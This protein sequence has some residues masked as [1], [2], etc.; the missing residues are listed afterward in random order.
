MGGAAATVRPGPELQLSESA[1]QLVVPADMV[2]GAY[3]VTVGG[4]APFVCG[5]PDIWW[6]QGA[7]GNHSVAGSWMRVFGR[8]MALPDADDSTAERRRSIKA[9]HLA[10]R[11]KRAAH[12]G[13]WE[14]VAALAKELAATAGATGQCVVEEG[15]AYDGDDIL[16]AASPL[17]VPDADA[18]CAACWEQATCSAWTY[19][20]ATAAAGTAGRCYLKTA[21]VGG[22]ARAEFTSGTVTRPKHTSTLPATTA[23]LCL[24]GG[25]CTTLAADSSTSQWQARFWLPSTL[26]PGEYR[27]QVSNGFTDQYMSAFI[28]TSTELKDLATVTVKAPSDPRVAWPTKVFEAKDYGCDGGFF[29]G[30][31]NTSGANPTGMNCSSSGMPCKTVMLARFDRCQQSLPRQRRCRQLPEGLQR[32]GPGGDRGRGRGGGRRC[33]AWR[34]AVVPGGPAAAAG[35]RAAAGGRDGP[36]GHLLRLPQRLQHAQHHDRRRARHPAWRSDLPACPVRRGR[37]GHLHR[38][39]LRERH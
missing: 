9:E 7:G 3:E 6:A 32:R 31:L 33:Q 5:A 14:G 22:S 39:A 38:I 30:T 12:V 36:H 29:K 26:Q 8:N 18:C 37:L 25:A 10:E 21:P 35:Q 16:P 17:M 34:W 20:E 4:G 28:G 2:H 1:A 23:T 19:G 24:E 27:L 11:S 13:D 15:K